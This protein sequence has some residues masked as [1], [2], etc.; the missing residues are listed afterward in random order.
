[1]RFGNN[2]RHAEMPDPKAGWAASA[3]ISTAARAGASQQKMPTASG[4]A[5]LILAGKQNVMLAHIWRAEDSFSTA[6]MRCFH[7]Q[8]SQDCI[9]QGNE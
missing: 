6:K 1:M 9:D 5:C 4:A 2:M 8:E 7:S 3:I